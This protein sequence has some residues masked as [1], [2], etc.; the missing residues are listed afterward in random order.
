MLLN[1][2]VEQLFLDG[3][4]LGFVSHTEAGGE[5]ELFKIGT[6]GLQI[7]R[8]DGANIGTAERDELTVQI[9]VVGVGGDGVRQGG[10]N[11]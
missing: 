2:A 9:A 1:Q 10:G 11:A 3:N 8:V 5:S 4:Q 7:K 6:N